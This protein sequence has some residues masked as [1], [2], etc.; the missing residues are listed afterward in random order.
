MVF[1]ETVNLPFNGEI[2]RSRF[3]QIKPGQLDTAEEGYWVILQKDALLL[4]TG[5]LYQ[6]DLPTAL[7]VSGRDPLLFGSWDGKP[8]RVPRE[9]LPPGAISEDSR[10]TPVAAAQA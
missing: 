1:P 7:A 5:A 4:A 3:T 8:V 9:C 10:E 2:I 6:G